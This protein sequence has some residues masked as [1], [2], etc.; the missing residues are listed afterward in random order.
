[1]AERLRGMGARV[2]VTEVDGIKALEAFM[3]GFELLPML[4]AALQGDVFLTCTGQI[5][6]IRSEHFDK[7]KNGA[8]IGN[9]GHFDREIDVVSLCKGRIKTLVRKNVERIEFNREKSLFLLC[10]GRVVNLVAA[11]G[12]PPEIMQLSFSNQLLS[13]Y[14]LVEN[15]KELR[16]SKSKMLE[17][18]KEIDKLVM[19]FA[20]KGFGIRIDN[21]TESQLY[22]AGSS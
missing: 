10:E 3:D 17:F 4:Q 6:V 8:V 16:S 21:L 20:M 22:Y 9:V 13:L 15:G 7:M 14:Y 11:E 1:M 2:L 18:P 12:H 19:T 5:D